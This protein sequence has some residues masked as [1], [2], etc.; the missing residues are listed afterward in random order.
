MEKR[1]VNNHKRHEINSKIRTRMK[2]HNSKIKNK[3]N[4]SDFK[5]QFLI[6]LFALLTIPP[7][8]SAYTEVTE[9]GQLS[10]EVYPENPGSFTK[11]WISLV[12]YEIDLDRSN[13]IWTI[14]SKK[15][16][17]GIGQ[18]GINFITGDVGK[19]IIVEIDA[20]DQNKIEI[21]KTIS[22][23]PAEV[24]LLWE[25]DGQV[26]PFYRG[27]A[28]PTP[29][30]NIKL[31]AMTNFVTE[32]GTR[33]DPS[34]LVYKWQANS[35]DLSSVY[36]KNS[37]TTSLGSLL[38]KNDFF[39]DVSSLDEKLRAT[40]FI[41]LRPSSPKLLFYKSTP[42]SGPNYA[43]ALGQ[44][45]QMDESELSLVAI[46]YFFSNQSE[47]KLLYVWSLNNQTLTSG[48]DDQANSITL[49]QPANKIGRAKLN[50]DVLG[51]YQPSISNSLDLKFGQRNSNF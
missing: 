5:F 4:I 22:I 31:V 21:K 16:K 24:D 50:L 11:V 42:L 40:K 23:I 48:D 9:G 13:I 41:N 51:T 37:V 1:R 14:N 47:N 49:R 3:K 15:Q 10:A 28:L 45:L 6:L 29:G 46:P 36:G 12:S 27:K 35:E 39:V 43:E 30:N 20:T 33:V 19:K 38:F 2:N 44:N 7:V 26:P 34:R 25:S 32:G 17:E 18:K 8:S